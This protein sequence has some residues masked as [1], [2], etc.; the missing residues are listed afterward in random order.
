MVGDDLDNEQHPWVVLLQLDNLGLQG[1]ELLGHDGFTPLLP[2]AWLPIYQFGL[3]KTA[4][5]FLAIVGGP[6]LKV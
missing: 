1:G 5:Q 2:P 4:T 6:E 3:D